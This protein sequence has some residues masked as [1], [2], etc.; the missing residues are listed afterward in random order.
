MVS[1]GH[2]FIEK[3]TMDK[4]RTILVPFDFS[5]ASRAALDYAVNYVGTSNNMH[6]KLLYADKEA[7][8]SALEKD[9]QN[10]RKGYGKNLRSP[11]SWAVSKESLTTAILKA[12]ESFKADLIIMGTSGTT[13]EEGTVTH[14][15]ELVLEAHCPVLVIPQT[16]SEFQVK[17]MAL[18]LGREEIEDTAVLGTLLDVARRFNARVHVLTIKNEPG[19]YG[20]SPA[21]EKNEKLLEYY[22]ESFYAHHMYIENPDIVKG[23]SEY[24]AEKEIDMIVI[25]P[26]KHARKSTPSE[27]RLTQ[28]LTLQSQTPILAIE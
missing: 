18:V 26:R 13:G 12:R 23:I 2:Q 27:G 25:L 8:E 28:I 15:A 5:E 19:E 10:V 11:M 7:V 9:F 22:L 1:L 21:D 20:Y 17:N 6:I 14:T 4:I 3:F 24:A 16:T